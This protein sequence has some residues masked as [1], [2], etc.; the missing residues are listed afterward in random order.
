MGSTPAVYLAPCSNSDAQEHLERTVV[1]GVEAEQYGQYTSVDFGD[2]VSI[3]GV[4]EGNQSHWDQL[5]AGDYLFFYTGNEEYSQ[6][7]EVLAT[8]QNEDLA[9]HLWPGFDDTWKYII[10]LSSPIP[11]EIDSSEV[12]DYADYNQNYIL[13][14]PSLAKRTTT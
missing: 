1:E 14:H 13:G 2:S 8:E 5:T 7:A 4:K 10:Y 9:N 6:V 12:A 3:W 11:V